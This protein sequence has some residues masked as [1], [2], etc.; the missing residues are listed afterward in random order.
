MSQKPAKP[1]STSERLVRDIRRATRKHYR[2]KKR[3]ALCWMA[4]AGEAT[5]EGGTW[6]ADRLERASHRHMRFSTL[7]RHRQEHVL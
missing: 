5:I 2:R 3:S 4:C 1:Q 7:R 6:H